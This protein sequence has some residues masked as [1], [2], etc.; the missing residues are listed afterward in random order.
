VIE[1]CCFTWRDAEGSYCCDEP[2]WA[3][4]PLVD[5]A[6]G[7]ELR[8]I[9]ARMPVCARHLFEILKARAEAR[10]R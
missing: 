6:T 10:S 7:G 4:A 5:S 1:R 3:L 2:A 8:E 9:P